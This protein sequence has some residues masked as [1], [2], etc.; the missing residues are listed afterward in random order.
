VLRLFCFLQPRSAP[1]ERGWCL[2]G[3]EFYGGAV[4]FVPY[5][6]LQEC[7]P[8]VALIAGAIA[9]NKPNFLV[10]LGKVQADVGCTRS[11]AKENIGKLVDMGY[12]EEA[13]RGY[14]VTSKYE[15]LRGA[16]SLKVPQELAKDEDLTALEKLLIAYVVQTRAHGRGDMEDVFRRDVDH[17]IRKLETGGW[18]KKVKEGGGRGKCRRYEATE[19]AKEFFESDAPTPDTNED[20]PRPVRVG[21]CSTD[22]EDYQDELESMKDRFADVD[23][24]VVDNAVLE[25]AIHGLADCF[26]GGKPVDIHGKTLSYMDIMV[27]EP[28]ADTSALEKVGS[29]IREEQRKGRAIE[30]LRGYVV[31]ALLTEAYE[32]AVSIGK[33]AE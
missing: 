33:L 8:I 17:A 2:P 6:L 27:C 31:T 1:V 32:T 4:F 11:T 20:K 9:C 5:M 18:I 19:K 28:F 30:N 29:R 10:Y 21:Q 22:R 7:G 16:E 26:S 25:A 24:A 14:K 3:K 23:R 12:V 13:R 15:E